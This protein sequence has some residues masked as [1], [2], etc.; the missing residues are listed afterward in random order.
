[1]KLYCT[2]TYIEK[3]GTPQTPNDLINHQC[4]GLLTDN[5]IVRKTI[6]FTHQR[7]GEIINAEMPNKITT[8]NL[9]NNLELIKSHEMIAAVWEKTSL[10]HNRD[11][12][13]VLAEYEVEPVH[14]YL[15][16]HPYRQDKSIDLLAEFIE[17]IFK[18]D[19]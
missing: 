15:L 14:L 9:M 17:K 10:P 11:F 16:K 19:N 2:K 5:L 6:A 12:V 8:N 13:Q 4:V 1:V 7:T 18:R 3:Y